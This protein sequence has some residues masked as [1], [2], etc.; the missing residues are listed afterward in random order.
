MHRPT[1]PP[2]RGRLI[3]RGKRAKYTPSRCAGV[4]ATACTQGKRAQHGK[5]D[6]VVGRDDQPETGDGQRGRCRVAERSAL[7]WRPGN[8]GGGKGPQFKT[9]V[10]RGEVLEIGA[11]LANSAKA[12]QPRQ[13]SH[14]EV[15]E[16]LGPG[17]G[18]LR[19]A[20]VV[21]S[22]VVT[23]RPSELQQGTHGPAVARS[24]SA[25]FRGR[26]HASCPR[27]GCVSSACPVR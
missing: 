11:T 18:K 20:Q 17:S 24:S 3:R 12:R 15:K 16:G 8:A 25:T 4:V 19:L 22:A 14:A 6:G 1:R 21:A 23:A 7:P 13:T 10:E 9:D 27:A 26:K 5:P 2:F